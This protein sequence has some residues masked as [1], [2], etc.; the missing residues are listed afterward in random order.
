M[1]KNQIIG[2]INLAIPIIFLYNFFPILFTSYLGIFA[3]ACGI[4]AWVYHLH[5]KQLNNMITSLQYQPQ[6]LAQYFN[7]LIKE[8]NIDPKT[9]QIRYAFTQES[10]AMTAKNTII[11]DP[12]VWHELEQDNQAKKVADVYQDHVQKTLAADQKARIEQIK[13]ALSVPVQRFIFKHELGHAF[14]NYSEKK[15]IGLALEAGIAA[16][17]GILLAL[18]MLPIIGGFGAIVAGIGI[19]CMIDLALAWVLNYWKAGHELQADA[20]AARYSN[21]EDIAAA[22]QFYLQHDQIIPYKQLLPREFGAGYPSGKKRADRLMTFL[23]KKIVQ[24]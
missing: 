17:V 10:I 16:F 22:A 21:A 20:F 23:D 14:Y 6:E 8:C 15:L 11:V 4:G 1:L 12:V 9:L 18:L 3:M 5:R 19:S 13:M 24:N 2:T 7:E